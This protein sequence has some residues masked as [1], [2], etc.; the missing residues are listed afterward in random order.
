M[1]KKSDIPES[2]E[3]LKAEGYSDLASLVMA[4][5]GIDSKEKAEE[6]LHSE[7]VHDPAMIRNIEK[8]SEIIWDHIYKDQKICVFGDYDADGVTG[9]AIL[10]L[11]LKR[12]GADV[13]ARLP[14]RIYEGYG[15]SMA[16]I[17]EEIA[18]GTKLFITIDNGIKCNE[19]I[20]EIRRQG[21]MSIVLDHHQPGDVLPDADA[22]IDLW[23][24]G[25]TYPFRELTGSGLA[26]KVACYMLTQV[27]D[28][29]YA[30]SLVDLAA[31]GTIADVAPLLGENRSI[32]KRALRQMQSCWYSRE[33]I[34]ALYDGDLCRITAEDIA[35]QIAPCINAS[36]RLEVRGADLPLLLLF[37]DNPQIA[38]HIAKR[39]RTI[40]KERKKI[41]KDW[42][43][44]MEKEAVHM[45]ERGD[46]VL[47][48]LADGAPAGIVGLIAGNLK[49]K[50]N[51][52]IIV[53]SPKQ[54]GDGRIEWVGSGRSIPGFHL[55][56]ALKICED[57][58]LEYGGH[59]LAAG[60]SLPASHHALYE[61]RIRINE[62]AT[63][64]TE[65]DLK[66]IVY[67]DAEIEEKDLTDDLFRELRTLEPFGEG[68]RKPVFRMPMKISPKRHLFMGK[69]KSH[70]KLYTDNF[71][72]VGFGLAEKF[73]RAD[74]PAFML[75]L[76]CLGENYYN[77]RELR[78]FRLIDFEP[79][80][81]ERAQRP[82]RKYMNR[83]G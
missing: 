45:V 37:E 32:V 70:L 40:N 55:L 78:E 61:F 1:W 13:I 80:A 47:V 2:V 30:M 26:W 81:D 54:N 18:I 23:V 73:I 7:T 33:G 51:R 46:K 28:Y 56:N 76:G 63:H 58:F 21:C 66:P 75:G 43:E 5:A 44:R 82:N 77:H 62:A 41:Q 15:I 69:D 29:D 68:N 67:W 3:I 20:E 48:M 31:I 12:L 65:E 49:E 14:D 34:K 52:P 35:F 17:Q 25:E 27:D 36:G 79:L 22:L 57:L 39:I 6:F 9:A 42:C 83:K 53:F 59:E 19:E 64:L 72:A 10:Y 60:I 16:A 71:C 4:K 11:M 8:V 74:L 50:Y 38:Q 24:E